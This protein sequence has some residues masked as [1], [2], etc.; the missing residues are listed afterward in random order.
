RAGF[1]PHLAVCPTDRTSTLVTLE[2]AAKDGLRDQLRDRIATDPAWFLE[3]LL[4]DTLAGGEDAR[5]IVVI[6]R[7]RG[8]RALK[9]L[10]FSAAEHALKP[11]EPSRLLEAELDKLSSAVRALVERA[12]H[13]EA[14]AV[15]TPSGVPA[16]EARA[17][18]P[19]LAGA[20]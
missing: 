6:D 16:L 8:G 18:D 20:V 13:L 19:G 11:V 12:R 9:A 2:P 15:E 10:V 17:G 5:W 3:P 14:Q 7:E 1:K 4:L